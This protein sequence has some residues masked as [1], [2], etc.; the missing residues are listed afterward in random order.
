MD[1]T[2]AALEAATALLDGL[3]EDTPEEERVAAQNAKDAAET[4]HEQAGAH[5]AALEAS[6]KALEAKS[7]A[8]ASLQEALATAE[9]ERKEEESNAK[10]ELDAE[11]NPVMKEPI[12][13]KLLMIK[14]ELKAATEVVH[15]VEAKLPPLERLIEAEKAV[16]K[17][18]THF[19]FLKAHPVTPEEVS[20]G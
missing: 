8:E 3:A 11:G 19:A 15:D 17:A 12:S 5:G 2:A 10:P 13:Q 16:K 1:T 4:A 20:G 18:R 6:K 9:A 14:V 7:A